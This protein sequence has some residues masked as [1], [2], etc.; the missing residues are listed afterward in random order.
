MP[1][2]ILLV[3]DDREQALLFTQVLEMSGYDVTAVVHAHDAQAQLSAHAYAL[4][5][6]DW[7]LPGD[8]QGDA[9][10]T[11]AKHHNAALR[12]VL[13][14]NH[15]RVLEVADACGADAGFRK[16]DGILKLRALM[17]TL[18]PIE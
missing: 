12:T 8:L 18:T 5:L 4:L 17:T 15:S 1:A 3:E 11:W 13:F 7:D 2:R 16:T 10:I 9:L 14:S 6:T